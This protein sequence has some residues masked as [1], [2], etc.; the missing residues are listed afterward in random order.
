MRGF[1][2]RRKRGECGL[3]LRGHALVGV[4]R[5]N[6]MVS[7]RRDPG[8]PL[9]GNC[10][11]LEHEHARAGGAGECGGVIGRPAIDDDHFV[12]PA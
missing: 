1:A 3:Q 5:Q 10:I 12:G 6:P 2:R 7:R 11:V 9:R 4:E 8:V